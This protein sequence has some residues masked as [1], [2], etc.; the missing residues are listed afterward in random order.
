MAGELQHLPGEFQAADRRAAEFPKLGLRNTLPGSR[1]LHQQHI[2]S[3]QH[4]EAGARPRGPAPIPRA[5]GGHG[6]RAGE[7]GRERICEAAGASGAAVVGVLRVGQISADSVN[8][9]WNEKEHVPMLVRSATEV[10]ALP[11]LH[12]YEG[13]CE[14]MPVDTVA[15]TVLQLADK[16]AA[17]GGGGSA[18][19]SFYNIT[20]SHAFSWND[21]FLPVLREA[22][23][24]FEEVDLS[25]WLRRLRARASELGAAAE[26]KLPAIKLADY[27]ET[28]Y[29][30]SAAGYGSNLK[31]EN[32]RACSDSDALRSCP[33]LSQVAIVSKMLQHWLR[34]GVQA[35]K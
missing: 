25:E 31:F 7:T 6:L 28:T 24:E 21:R 19:A 9:I 14:W 23:L 20:P 10:G 33:E 18:G 34:H 1:R 5:R 35:T 3:V 30:E 11:R 26:E 27:Y 22:G 2:D 32:D 12:G 4:G 8:G 29:G 13:R 15:A 17:G 16:L